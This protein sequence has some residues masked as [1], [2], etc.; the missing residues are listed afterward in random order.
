MNTFLTY[1]FLVDTIKKHFK[2]FFIGGIIAAFTGIIIAYLLP[3]EYVSES[4]IFPARHF[5]VS[6]MLVEPNVGNQEDYLEIGDDDDME[7]LMQIIHSDNL[8]ILLADKLNL[9]KRWKIDN[10]EYKL[11]Y[12]KSKWDHYIDISRTIFTSLKIKVYDTHP[13]TAAL[14]AN[15]IVEMI[16]SVQKQMS[17]ERIQVAL[18][19]VK[20]EYDSTIAR[21]NTME[22][23]LNALRKLGVLEYKEQVKAFS[24]EYAKCIA[25]G[26]IKGKQNM[27]AAIYTLEKFGGAYNNVNEE[28][29]KYRAKFAVIK[30]KYDQMLIDANYVL[31]LKYQVQKAIPNNKKARP[32]KWLITIICFLSVEIIIFSFYLIFNQNQK[33]Q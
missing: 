21:I 11:Y 3:Q 5:S 27:E 22:D 24:K 13:D 33:N 20:R 29:R 30:N 15:T 6:K 7:K 26:D 16:D 23:S 1:H 8:K 18:D 31:P 2:V 10:K 14:I 25:K 9:W 12:L 28:L 32:S 17:K 19:I 4:I